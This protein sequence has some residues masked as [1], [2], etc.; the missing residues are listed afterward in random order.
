MSKEK[1]T[2]TVGGIAMTDVYQS[3]HNKEKTIA[4]LKIAT[5]ALIENDIDMI[6]CEVEKNFNE[7]KI[8]YKF[9]SENNNISFSVF[10]KC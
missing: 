2:I 5:K 10:S 3:T 7:C 6:I 1:D 8:K 4:E 9:L